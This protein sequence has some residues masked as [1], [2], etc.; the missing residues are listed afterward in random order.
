GDVSSRHCGFG[1]LAVPTGALAVGELVVFPRRAFAPAP[2]VRGVIAAATGV[3][4]DQP[5]TRAAREDAVFSVVEIIPGDDLEFVHAE[6]E[7]AYFGI[8][9]G[10]T[11]DLEVADFACRANGPCGRF[12]ESQLLPHGDAVGIPFRVDDRG[13][14]AGDR[15]AARL[16]ADR[17]TGVRARRDADRVARGGFV[18]GVLDRRGATGRRD[19]DRPCLSGRRQHPP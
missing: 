19:A 4:A 1:L 9:H 13:R 14:A 11:G 5:V 15:Q 17:R 8:L 2:V 18:D 6:Q 12:F 10:E 3:P 16:H 7:Y